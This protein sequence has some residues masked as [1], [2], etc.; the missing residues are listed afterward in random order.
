M[1]VENDGCMIGTI[2]GNGGGEACITPTDNEDVGDCA[3]SE[4]RGWVRCQG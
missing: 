1:G 2:E 4:I 3:E